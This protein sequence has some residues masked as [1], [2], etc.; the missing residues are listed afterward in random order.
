MGINSSMLDQPFISV[1]IPVYNGGKYI[2]RCLDALIPSIYPAFEILVIDDHS[3]DDTVKIAQQKGVNVLQLTEQQGPATAR[4]FGTQHARG[5][6]FLFVDSDVTVC[7][8]TIALVAVNFQQNPEIAAVFGSYD[9]EPLEENFMSQYRN[10][11][12]HFHHQQSNREAFTFW[13]GC[14]AIRKEVF[15]E[16]GGFNQNRYKKPCIEDI[17]LGRRLRQKGYN[18]LLDKMLQVKHLKQW[19]FLD[20]IRT[21]ILQRAIPW[22]RLILET[23]SKPKDLNMKLSHKISSFFVALLFLMI[24]FIF[25]SQTYLFDI[26]LNFVIYLFTLLL[27]SIVILLNKKLYIFFAQK[28]GLVFVMQAFPLHLL[29][30]LYS[31]FSFIFCWITYK[32]SFLGFFYRIIEDLGA[33]A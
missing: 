15:K 11:F 5:E 20:L 22:S 21:D 3:T 13:A 28:R 30:Y 32:I 1:I 19:K 12:H 8:D 10:L 9:D 29:Y 24:L 6:I 16:I 4:N 2:E 33:R 18:I 7:R 23:G 31:G 25:L 17:E 26:K 14:G 27:L